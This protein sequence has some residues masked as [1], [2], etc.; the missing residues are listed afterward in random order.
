MAGRKTGSKQKL[1]M[2]P[3]GTY[4]SPTWVLMA[5][6]GDVDITMGKATSD[7]DTRETP[8]TKTVAGNKKLGITFNYFRVD[9]HTD[10]V[11]NALAASYFDDTVLDMAAMEIAI[12]TAGAK[13]IRGPFVVTKFDR[14]EAVNEATRYEVELA[15]TDEYSSDGAT[16][17]FADEYVVP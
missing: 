6:V 8:N 11:F 15:E 3:A 9:S 16:A 14:K 10:A 13:G 2:N 1:Y 12:A 5:K 7:V 17:Y 4:A